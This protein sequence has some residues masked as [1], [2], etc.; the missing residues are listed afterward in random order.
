MEAKTEIR[1]V[2]MAETE[3]HLMKK[4]GKI[5]AQAEDSGRCLTSQELDDVKD[6]WDTLKQMY[7][8]HAM[9]PKTS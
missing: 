7:A 9:S 8:V 4:L 1:R 3:E 2:R 5:Y 6:I